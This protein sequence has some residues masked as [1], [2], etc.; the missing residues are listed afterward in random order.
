M[1]YEVTMLDSRYGVGLSSL[2]GPADPPVPGSRMSF[3][4]TAYCK[5]PVTTSGVAAQQGVAAADP[6]VL[7][8]GSVV[9]VE[10]RDGQYDGIY[11]VLDT[12]PSVQGRHVDLYI[13]N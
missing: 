8:I 9:Q 10:S 7:P 5:G 2:V 1:L 6:Q 12:G 11:S 4:A 13:W 3:T